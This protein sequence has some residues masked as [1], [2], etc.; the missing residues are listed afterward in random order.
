MKWEFMKAQN[1][2]RAQTDSELPGSRRT[3]GSRATT[4][5]RGFKGGAGM[6]GGVP[7]AGGKRGSAIGAPGDRL[8]E[9]MSNI[10]GPDSEF[11]EERFYSLSSQVE[12]VSNFEDRLE[13]IVR[14]M[15]KVT[16]G[17][18]K[19]YKNQTQ[20]RHRLRYNDYCLL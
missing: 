15:K 11:I 8:L 20:V 3:E 16:L 1:V 14:L 6:T 19:M 2:L 10:F 4:I 5:T 13:K 9:D 12:R 18:K 7:G 17:V